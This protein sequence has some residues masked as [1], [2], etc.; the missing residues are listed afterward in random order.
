MLFKVFAILNILIFSV[1]LNCFSQVKSSPDIK[2]SISEIRL[3]PNLHRDLLNIESRNSNIYSSKIGITS[4]DNKKS[5]GLG[6]LLSL[7]IPG[8]GHLYAGRM[9]VGKYFV[10]AEALS[11]IGLLGLNLYGNYLR[12]D[13]R[14]FASVHAGFSKNGKDDNYYSNI[15]NYDNIYQYND[16]K[17]RKGQYDQL[18]DVNSYFWNWDD[19]NNRVIFDS[20]RKKSERVYNSRVIFASTLVVNRLVSA[21]S[22]LIL[23]NSQN[24][25]AS[26]LNFNAEVLTSR[27]NSIDGLKINLVKSF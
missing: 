22:T 9:D 20:Q 1:Y 14:S 24:K 21:I 17:L 11:W 13:S 18:Y 8:A 23:I 26:S 12:D 3:K 6:I 16:D 7:A 5:P 10:T 15:T 4:D 2:S 27:D 25:N 19:Y